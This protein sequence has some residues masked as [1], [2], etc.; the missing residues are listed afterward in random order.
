M[1]YCLIKKTSN[2]IYVKN[3]KI[4]PFAEQKPKYD[5]QVNIMW[6]SALCIH[7]YNNPALFN[8]SM[9]FH[10]CTIS[11]LGTGADDAFVLKRG[12]AIAA[13]AC[14]FQICFLP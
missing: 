4:A 1:L 8:R 10:Y 3:N 5:Q 13:S 11:N 2:C 9:Q 6:A 12:P 7:F 14:H